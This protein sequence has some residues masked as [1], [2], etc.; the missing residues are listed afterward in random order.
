MRREILNTTGEVS[1]EVK[2]DDSNAAFTLQQ[3]II[4][5]SE[6]KNSLEKEIEVT[7]EKVEEN[8]LIAQQSEVVIENLENDITT[9]K[10]YIA[11]LNAEAELI[12]K[13]IA[14]SN[15]ILD[16]YKLKI[17]EAKTHLNNQNND[18]K[19]SEQKALDRIGELY[20]T[21]QN[22]QSQIDSKK[23]EI[24]KINQDYETRVESLKDS[25]QSLLET[26]NS[27]QEQVN[28]IEDKTKEIEDLNKSIDFLLNISNETKQ[29]NDNATEM[30]NAKTLE[31]TSKNI[32]I[33]NLDKTIAEKERALEIVTEMIDYKIRKQEID[34]AKALIVS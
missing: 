2:H 20:S 18:F 14:E 8:K 4:S 26:I 3:E 19:E 15:T 22:Y 16:D 28:T 12:S 6:T 25:E 33:E 32:I 5:L 31:I 1:E 24:E 9:I 17:E 10:S 13:N 30:L 23:N 7:K 11:K 29:L 34:S 21:I 27:Y